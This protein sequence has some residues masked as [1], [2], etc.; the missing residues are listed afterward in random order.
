MRRRILPCNHPLC[1]LHALFTA[2]SRLPP[3]TALR[4]PAYPLPPPRPTLWPTLWPQVAK[5]FPGYNNDEPFRGVVHKV[6]A[7][8]QRAPFYI[9]YPADADREWMSYEE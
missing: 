5:V 8:D 6:D 9:W 7:G 2:H 1:P 3:H 4:P